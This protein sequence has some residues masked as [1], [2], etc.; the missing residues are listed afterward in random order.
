MPTPP[1]RPAVAKSADPE[2]D[3]HAV[4]EQFVQLKRQCGENVEGFTYERF[5]ETLIKNRE[6]LVQQ[7][8]AQEVRFAVYIKE[9]RAALKASPIR[10]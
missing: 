4:F 9:G 6:A 2:A 10:S 7:H 5:R 3:W 8:G 1:A